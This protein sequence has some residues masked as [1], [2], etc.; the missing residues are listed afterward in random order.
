M[1]LR[2][3]HRSLSVARGT[4]AR[5]RPRAHL[6]QHAGALGVDEQRLHAAEPRKHGRRDRA[7]GALEETDHDAVGAQ[8]E[9]D[10]GERGEGATSGSLIQRDVS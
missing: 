6:Q 3:L 1:L 10:L 7:A 8:E 2:V 5:A 4:R 9:A